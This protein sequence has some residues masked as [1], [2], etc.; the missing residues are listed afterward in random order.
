MLTR[1]NEGVTNT[2]RMRMLGECYSQGMTTLQSASVSFSRMEQC[3]CFMCLLES[4]NH[5]LA[6]CRAPSVNLDCISY[7]LTCKWS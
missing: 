5:V 2:P 1:G 6:Y 3:L 4:D 7:V